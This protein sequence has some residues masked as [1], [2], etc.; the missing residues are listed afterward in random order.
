MFS[1]EDSG[2]PRHALKLIA[3]L[4]WVAAHAFP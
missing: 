2:L 4:K 3:F 1:T